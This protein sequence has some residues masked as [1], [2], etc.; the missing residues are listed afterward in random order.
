M[1]DFI[2]MINASLFGP[3][4]TWG[5]IALYFALMLFIA[6]TKDHEAWGFKSGPIKPLC[7][8]GHHH[9]HSRRYSTDEEKA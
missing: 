4:V 8:S 7:C 3:Y 9:D 6:F 5:L 1:N 2:S